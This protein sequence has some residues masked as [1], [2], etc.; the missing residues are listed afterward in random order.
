VGIDVHKVSYALAI[1]DKEGQR[2]KV[3]TPVSGEKA[4]GSTF[5][6]NPLI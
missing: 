3:F 6:N 5:F 4:L 1:L 2:L